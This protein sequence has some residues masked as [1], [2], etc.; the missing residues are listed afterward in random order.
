MHT[1]RMRAG[2]SVRTYLDAVPAPAAEY[3]VPTNN[4]DSQRARLDGAVATVLA[5]GR[6]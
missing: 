2:R 4:I 5:D 6:V 1:H 3:G